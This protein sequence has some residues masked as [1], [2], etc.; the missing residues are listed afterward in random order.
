MVLKLFNTLGRKKQEFKPIHGKEVGIYTCGPTVYWYQ[1]IGNLRSYIFADILKR[2]LIYDGF[3]VKH[4]MNVTDVGHLTSDADSGEDKMEKAALKEGKK[5]EDIANYYWKIFR[6]DFKKLNIIEPNIWC[7]ATEH[8]KE[9]IELIKKLEEKGYTYETSDGI[10]F[11][12]SKY[13]D[14]GKLAL[15]N[16]KGLEAGK[17]IEVGDKRNKTDFA[18]WKFSEEEGKRQQEWKS[19]WGIGFP[20]WHIECSAMSSKYLGEQFDIHTG[21]EDHIPIHH[22]NE[23]C[24]SE[25]AFGKKPWVNYWLHGAFLTFKGEKV[26]KSKGGLFT[27]SE[28]EEKE[29]KP[30]EYRYFCLNGHYR[31]QLEFSI[32][33]LD[34]AKNSLQRLKR[35]ISSLPKDNENSKIDKKYLEEFENAINDDL[36]MP[37]A[38]SVLWKLVRDEKAEGKIKTIKKMDEVFGLDLL[39]KEEIKI[40]HEV[41]K[42]VEEREKARKTKDFKKSDELR[43]K[44][45]KLGFNVADSKEGVKISKL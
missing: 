43:D 16:V 45:N 2:V 36:D 11:D 14:Y 3:K 38:L 19:P 9:Q 24:Q 21:G 26:S 18:L 37:K 34:N 23:I 35:I 40:P 42:L 12:T 13:K 30:L 4:V 22:T 15:L 8:I 1:H 39:K 33:N 27:I 29:Y 5:A 7:K 31:T 41:Q 44:I 28:L 25:C 17:R 6:E 32:E 20:G 10:Y